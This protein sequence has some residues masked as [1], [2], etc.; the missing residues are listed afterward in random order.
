MIKI[1]SITY[2]I[3]SD[4]SNLSKELFCYSQEWD[5]TFQ[6]HTQRINLSESDS[7]R[8]YLNRI[9]SYIPVCECSSV[10]W[11][12]SPINCRSTSIKDPY[13]L[14]LQIL[15]LS[16]STFVNLI[17]VQQN[18]IK[19]NEFENYSK[20]IKK[21]AR[22][23]DTGVNNFRLGLSFNIGYNCPF[24]PFTRAKLNENSFSIGL[25][26][27]EEIN[28]IIIESKLKSLVD[29]KKL[30]IETLEKQVS[31]IY[32]FAINFEAKHDLKFSGFD[33]SIAPVISELGSVL[34]LLKTVGISS[35]GAVGTMFATA[36]WTDILGTLKSKF[37]SV[38]FSGMMYSILEDIELC[39]LNNKKGIKAENFVSLSTMCGCGLDMLPIYED[40]SDQEVVSACLDIAAISYRYNKPL[41]VRL[42]PIPRILRGSNN[43]TSISDEVDFISNTKVVNLGENEIVNCNSPLMIDRYKNE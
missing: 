39:K 5:S 29:L 37:P 6:P 21:V 9:S 2:N 41:G 15:E 10:R 33:F 11:I 35:F 18:K 32:K 3:G 36:Y 1:R 24:F 40:T 27:V 22:L 13:K 23:D 14:A 20:L 38:V 19:T 28:R 16:G 25:E 12:N 42:L 17:S 8:K 34:P 26:L 43:Y 30:I 7:S 31:N 4:D